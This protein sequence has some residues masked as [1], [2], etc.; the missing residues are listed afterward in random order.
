MRSG[1]LRSSAKGS[2][3]ALPAVIGSSDRSRRT[4]WVALLPFVAGLIATEG[5]ARHAPQ[6]IEMYFYWG[7][8]PGRHSVVHPL[9][10]MF[11]QGLA[12]D[13]YL[14]VMHVNGIIGALAVLPL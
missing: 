3:L 8:F 7:E 13:P 10:E 9:Y 4:D 2:S 14:L 12:R 5:F 1:I 6:E 11:I